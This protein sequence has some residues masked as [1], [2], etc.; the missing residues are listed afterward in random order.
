MITDSDKRP[1]RRGGRFGGSPSRSKQRK[2]ERESPECSICKRP[3]GDIISALVNASD[4]SAV[5]F[6]CALKN[7]GESLKPKEGEKVI[8]C[9]NGSFAAVDESNYQ[10]NKLR[11]HR[12]IRWENQENKAEWWHKLRV[13]V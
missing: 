12:T 8:Y 11:I 4:R 9:G 3:I 5:H 7:A 6:D 10:Q 1:D 2:P 13:S